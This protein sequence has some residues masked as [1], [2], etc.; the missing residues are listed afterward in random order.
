MVIGAQN[1]RL[2]SSATGRILCRSC[3]RPI[4]ACVSARWIWSGM[5]NF[6]ASALTAVSVA[7]SSV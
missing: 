3:D 6:L 4:S 5:F 7:A 1:F 2:S